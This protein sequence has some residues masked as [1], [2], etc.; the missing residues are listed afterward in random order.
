M[1][2][3]VDSIR[4]STFKL[5]RRRAAASAH[6]TSLR[7]VTDTFTDKPSARS[8]DIKLDFIESSTAVLLKGHVT[9]TSA[10]ANE[11]NTAVVGGELGKLV[12]LL[13]GIGVGAGVTG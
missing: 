11:C 6:D 1:I 12:G 8:S 13:D 7:I 9:I 5:S 3:T 2:T 10:F 4:A